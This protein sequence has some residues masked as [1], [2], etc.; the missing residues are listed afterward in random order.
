VFVLFNVLLAIIVDAYQSAA[1]DSRETISIAQDA[2]LAL[3][4]LN[5]QIS[6]HSGRQTVSSQ[7]LAHTVLA[8]L[9]QARLQ[10][11]PFSSVANQVAVVNWCI[12]AELKSASPILRMHVVSIL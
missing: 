2:V 3:K 8:M 10:P 9:K 4:R 12:R 5:Y 6:A 7:R 1:N 11:D